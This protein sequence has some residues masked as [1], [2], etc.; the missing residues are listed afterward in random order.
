MIRNHPFKMSAFFRGRGQKL[1]EFADRVKKLPTVGGKGQKSLN[2]SEVL[3]GW[4]L[5][6]KMQ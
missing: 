3:N 1:A 5:M 2:F 6:G 4:S